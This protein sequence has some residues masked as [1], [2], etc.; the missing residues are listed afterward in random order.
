MKARGDE[1]ARRDAVRLPFL[2][3]AARQQQELQGGAA[4]VE[5]PD[6]DSDDPDADLD[7]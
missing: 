5:V 6:I 3:S 4:A 1:A 2:Y 7:I